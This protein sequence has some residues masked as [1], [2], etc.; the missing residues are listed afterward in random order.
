M[1]AAAASAHTSQTPACQ[2][3]GALVAVPTGAASESAA[4]A[5]RVCVVVVTSD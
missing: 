3:G 4:G 5:P 1:H 2:V